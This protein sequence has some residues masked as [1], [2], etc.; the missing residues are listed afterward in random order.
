MP[1]VPQAG[2][3]AIRT[4]GPVPEFLV[5]TAKKNPSHWIFPKGH[6]ET[7]ETPEQTALRELREEA[8]VEGELLARV[9]DVQLS[10]AGEDIEVIYYSVRAT[11]EVRAQEGRELQWLPYD[12]A[13][14]K[15][16][17]EDAK[18]L[19]DDANKALGQT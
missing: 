19:L 2:V 1:K 11:G 9:G 8:G 3:I 6:I 14:E 16:T 17:F 12:A 10:F 18:R 13:R 15:L 4:D 5:V 7:G